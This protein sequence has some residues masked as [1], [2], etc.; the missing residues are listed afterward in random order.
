MDISRLKKINTFV[1]DVDG[2]FTD[3]S[4]I[5]L[6]SGEQARVFDAKDGYAI[7]KAVQSGY[8][9]VII[10]GG[11]QQ[12]VKLRLEYLGVN[13][14]YLNV[15][16]KL[17]V[18]DRFREQHDLEEANILYMGDDIPDHCI[19][20]RPDIF[21]AC[22]ADAVEEIKQV[23]QYISP[24]AGGKRAVRDVVELV[25]KAQNKWDF[26]LGTSL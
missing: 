15:K 9:V 5:A 11:N 13:H 24:F 19:M 1:F 22:P 2:V 20:N 4:V 14:I 12:G 23:S 8:Q 26:L 10:S 7:T 21:A 6:Q 3:G 25:L 16:S 17:E 18:L